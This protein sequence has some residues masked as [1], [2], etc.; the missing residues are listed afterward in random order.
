MNRLSIEARQALMQWEPQSAKPLSAIQRCGLSVV[1]VSL[2]LGGALLIERFHVRDVAVPFFL[3]AVAVT[4]WYGG[5]GASVLALLL[6][7][8]TFDYFF[9]QPFHTLYISR[10]DLPYFVV[11][12]TFAWLVSWFSA[13]RR[14]VEG[15][16]RQARDK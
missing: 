11:F 14:R 10:S 16:L 12:A 8:I 3:F 7:C 15:E 2:A 6:S 9:V 1:S 4:A 5:A 13:V